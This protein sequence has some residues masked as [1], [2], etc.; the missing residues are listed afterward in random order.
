MSHVRPGWCM[1]LRHRDESP[2]AASGGLTADSV[3]EVLLGN[4]FH[5]TGVVWLE[6]LASSGSEA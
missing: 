3:E 6:S 1:I 2:L 5:R 4:N